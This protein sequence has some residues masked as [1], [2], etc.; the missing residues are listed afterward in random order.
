MIFFVYFANAL[1]VID[2]IISYWKKKY[3]HGFLFGIIAIAWAFVHRLPFGSYIY[4]LAIPFL[5]V[6]IWDL[7][8]LVGKWNIIK[9]NFVIVSLVAVIFV[10]LLMFLAGGRTLEDSSKTLQHLESMLDTQDAQTKSK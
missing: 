7:R 10:G 8:V 4:W 5:P 9:A 1:C 3:L 6:V 2:T